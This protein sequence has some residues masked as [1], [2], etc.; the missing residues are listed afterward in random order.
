M[1]PPSTSSSV[2]AGKLEKFQRSLTVFKALSRGSKPHTFG[3]LNV[4]DHDL[5][6][7]GECASEVKK[8]RL[9]PWCITLSD[10][11]KRGGGKLHIPQT[12]SWFI[13]ICLSQMYS[14]ASYFSHSAHAFR[15]KKHTLDV[16]QHTPACGSLAEQTQEKKCVS[17][18]LFSL[19]PPVLCV[20]KV[21]SQRWRDSLAASGWQWQVCGVLISILI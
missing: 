1:F 5:I 4:G 7:C 8:A 21:N 17:L 12:F 10:K 19:F 9:Q 11:E 2:F 18:D 20:L 3:T 13:I 14:S 16:E 6:C 15:K